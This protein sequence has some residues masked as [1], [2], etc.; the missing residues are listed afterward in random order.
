[1]GGQPTRASASRIVE[2]GETPSPSGIRFG[3]LGP[4]EAIGEA[5]PIALGGPKQ[6]MVLAHL[7]IRANQVVPADALIDLVWGENPPDVVR[8]SLQS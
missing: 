8:T 5:G 7:I 1:M 6:R 2:L 4:L 3:V